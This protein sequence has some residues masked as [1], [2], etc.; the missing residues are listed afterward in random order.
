MENLIANSKFENAVASLK[1][2]IRAGFEGAAV[3]IAT[4]M[5]GQRQLAV[6][7]A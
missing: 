1:A 5:G 4:L 7:N 2:G 3:E 6:L